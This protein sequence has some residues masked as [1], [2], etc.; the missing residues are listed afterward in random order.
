MSW[1][2]STI[3]RSE[4]CYTANYVDDTITVDFTNLKNCKGEDGT[5]IGLN[6]DSKVT[7]EYKA[8]LDPAKIFENGKIKKNSMGWLASLRKIRLR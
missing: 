2:R 8:K 3:P 7:V 6:S 4:V 1:S 5:A